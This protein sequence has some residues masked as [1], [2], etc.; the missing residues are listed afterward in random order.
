MVSGRGGRVGPDLS[1]AGAARSPEY[2][3]ESIRN[4]DKYI[5]EGITEPNKDLAQRYEQ[6]TAVTLAGE[7]IHGV[8]LNEDTFSLQMIDTQ[9]N[10]HLF[11][12]SE[13]REVVREK[14]SLMP[15]YKVD[16]LSDRDLDDLLAYLQSLR[17]QN[18]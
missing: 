4:P 13:L 9:E 1:R 15:A 6:V 5:A 2:L 10:L 7:R 11:L 17:G 12:K 3:R 8:A 14:K 18:Q 16:S